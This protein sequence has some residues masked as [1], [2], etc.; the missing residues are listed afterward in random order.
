MRCTASR[1]R[2][3]LARS[4]RKGSKAKLTIYGYFDSAP[5][6]VRRVDATSLSYF[7]PLDGLVG[8][9]AAERQSICREFGASP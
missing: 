9:V 8:E 1:L 2:D 6:L 7:L 5:T 4:F 3:P